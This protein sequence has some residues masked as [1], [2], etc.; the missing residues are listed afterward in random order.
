M[1]FIKICPNKTSAQGYYIYNLKIPSFYI[2]N[3]SDFLLP[4]IHPQIIK[5]RYFYSGQ[6]WHKDDRTERK[7]DTRR[8]R[9]KGGRGREEYQ[10]DLDKRRNTNLV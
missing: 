8:E 6:T 5:S 2:F 4:Y 7:E 1:L 3:Y 9:S 10:G